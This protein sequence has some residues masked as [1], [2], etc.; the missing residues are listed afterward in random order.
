M[1]PTVSHLLRANDRSLAAVAPTLGDGSPPLLIDLP[2]S[3]P[4]EIFAQRSDMITGTDLHRSISFATRGRNPLREYASFSERL[5]AWLSQC[6]AYNLRS[7]VNVGNSDFR[8]TCD[9]IG[10]AHV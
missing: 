5:F 4:A 1:I 10:R 3:R 8:G 7:E 6:G 2:V 9:Q